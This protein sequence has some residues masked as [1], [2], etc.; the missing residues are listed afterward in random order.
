[1]TLKYKTVDTTTLKGL[2]RAERLHAYGWKMIRV[3]L[4]SIQF[5]KKE[6]AT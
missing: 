5:E 1:M 6:G 2:K 4:F 3:G